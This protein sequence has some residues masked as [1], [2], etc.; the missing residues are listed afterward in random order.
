MPPTDKPD[1]PVSPSMPPAGPIQDVMPPANPLG[2]PQ[3]FSDNPVSDAG[4]NPIAGTAA[5][6]SSAVIHETPAGDQAL[7]SVLQNVTNNLKAAPQMPQKPKKRFGLFGGGNKK[8]PTPMP[9]PV[10]PT[11]Q[12]AV[13]QSAAQSPNPLQQK[14]VKPKKSAPIIPIFVAILAAIGLATA[15]IFAF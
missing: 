14:P 10:P 2:N 4:S 15:A 1:A 6:Q 12:A 11:P 9:R 5:A 3:N 13:S 8:Q 7:D